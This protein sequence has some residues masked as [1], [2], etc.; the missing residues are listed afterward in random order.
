MIAVLG[1]GVA[2]AAVA[3]A[4]ACR[5]AR[6]VVVFD[7]RGPGEGSTG[8]A[9]GGF[10]TQHGSDLNV[11]LAL[12]S[13]EYFASR[14]DRVKFQAVGY[15]YLAETAPAAAELEARA[16][17]QRDLGL[18]VTHPEPASKV[19]FLT[20][21]DLEGANFCELDGVYLPHLVLG[22][23]TEEAVAAGAEFRYGSAATTGEVN[24]AEAVVIAAGVWSSDVGRGLGVELNVTPVERGV[25][26]VGPFDWLRPIPMTLEAG[27]GYHFRERD[28]RLLVMGPGDQH[29]FG[30]FR[31]WLAHRAPK[32]AVERPERHWSGHYEM[33]PDHHGLVGLT[34]RPGTWAC[35]GFSG[36]GVM[37]APAI[38]EALAAMI[39]GETPAVDV[40]ALSP[41]RTARLV[42]RTQL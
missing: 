34:E 28:G 36:H 3:R 37:Q 15:L 30:H 17:L 22:A 2:G 40:A 42:D 11:R 31:Q 7:P 29:D 6:G 21:G 35:C 5:G 4:L 10:R 41:R 18:P 14:A 23:L 16:R 25:F 20:T 1:G 32:A 12:A 24:A 13:R 19:G 33:S 39:L 9:L 38:G 27:S 8:A 26:Q